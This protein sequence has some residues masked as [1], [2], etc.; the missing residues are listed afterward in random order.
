MSIA[1]RTAIAGIGATEFSK[2]SK[3]SEMR[4]AVEAASMALDDAGLSP[5]DVDG[6]STFTMDSNEE[7]EVARNLGAGDLTFFSRIHYGGGAACAVVHQ[8]AMAVATG[9][10]NVVVC[11]R[12]LNGRSW[13]RFG[14]S[15]HDKP[16][17]ERIHYGWYT[18]FGLTTP[19]SWVAMFAQRYLH[20]TGATTEDFGQVAV[21]HR[22]FAATNPRAWFHGK[23]ITLEDHAKSRWIVEPLRLLDCCQESDGG[24]AVIVTTAERARDLRQPPAVIKAAAQGSGAGQEEMT[25]YYRDDLTRI[26]EAEVVARRLWERSGVTPADVQ[27][28][29]IYDPFTPFVLMQLESFGF[30]EP[31]EAAAFVREKGIGPGGAL[32]VNTNGGQLGEGYIHGMNGVAEGVRQVRGQA[33]NQVDGVEN[34]L[35]TS[36][37]GVPTSGL[38]LGKDS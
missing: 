16:S 22:A 38:V 20:A 7:I 6:L 8:A 12:A 34:V 9:E 14:L 36:G 2:E 15:M 10:A 3:R 32:P 1:G 35:V 11:Y 29:V 21:A 17:A 23:P 30:C 5:K 18:P 19:A 26:P 33:A 25:S 27:T 31:G 28:A 13:G 24:V 37:V 4:L